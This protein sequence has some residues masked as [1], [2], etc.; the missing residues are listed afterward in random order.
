MWPWRT[1]AELVISMTLAETFLL[2]GVHD[3]VLGS[4]ESACRSANAA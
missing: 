4:A 2:L 3:L 1:R